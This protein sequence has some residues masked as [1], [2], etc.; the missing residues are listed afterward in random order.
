[1]VKFVRQKRNERYRALVKTYV[2][3][4]LKIERIQLGKWAKIYNKGGTT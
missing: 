3:Q 1:M 4:H 2:F